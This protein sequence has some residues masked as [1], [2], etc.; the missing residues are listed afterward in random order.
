[1][2]VYQRLFIQAAPYF[3]I[4]TFAATFLLIGIKLSNS[5]TNGYTCMLKVAVLQEKT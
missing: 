3:D 5:G 4:A 1:M 2:Y